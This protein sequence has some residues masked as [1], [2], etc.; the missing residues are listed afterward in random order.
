LRD[1]SAQF[2]S[3]VT[4]RPM[5]SPVLRQDVDH[6]LLTVHQRITTAHQLGHR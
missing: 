5:T 2:V 3:D 1:L 6:I 4:S